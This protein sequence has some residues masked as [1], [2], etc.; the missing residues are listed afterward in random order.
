MAH[1]ELRIQEIVLA[2]EQAQESLESDTKS[3][4]GDKY[5]TSR[6]MIQQ[7]LTRY[8]GQLLHAKKDRVILEQL[9][10][11]QTTGTIVLGSLV[12][13]N[14]AAYFMAISLGKLHVEGHDYMAISAASPIGQLFMGKQVG[15]VIDFNGAKQQILAVL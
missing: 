6:E 15:D 10:P 11:L 2:M 12:T 13:T 7:D 8:Q 9:D 1:T 14:K 3:S 5:E 4:A